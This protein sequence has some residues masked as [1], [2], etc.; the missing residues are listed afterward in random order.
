MKHFYY[1]WSTLVFVFLHAMLLAQPADLH[2]GCHFTKSQIPMRTLTPAEQEALTTSNERSDTL[3]ILNYDITLEITDFGGK[4]IHGSCAIAFT[5]VTEG[6]ETM[7]L[8]LLAL[9]IDSI[10]MD[11]APLP[12]S[13]DGNQITITFPESP[14]LSD[15]LE[16]EVFYGGQTTVAESNFGG[17]NFEQGIAYNLGIGLGE[18][19]YNFGRGWFPCFDNFVEWATYDLN[20]IST[21]T[22]RAYC[23]GTFLSEE[24]WEGNKRMRRYR[25]AQPLPTY[26]VGIA[27]SDFVTVDYVHSGQYGDHPVQLVARPT[28]IDDVVTSFEF[29]PDAIDIF[30]SWYGPYIWE[31]VGF[32]LTPRGAME[33]STN[34]AYPFGTGASGATPAQNRLMAHELAHH[35]WGNITTLS[36]PENMWIKEGNAEYGAHLFTEFVNGKDAFRRQVKSNLL[37]VLNSAHVDDD[38]YHP[39]SGIPYEHTYG[40]HTYQKGASMLHNMR[41]YLGDSLFT[42]GQK[43][44]L[45]H[46]TY[47][48]INAEQYRDHLTL[49][50]GVDMTDYFDAWIFN[51]GFANYELEAMDVTANGN[52]YDVNLI[53]QQKLHN[54][55]ELHQNAPVQVTFFGE[56]WSE[57]TRQF[58]A[59]G[60]FSSA[61]TTLPFE[62][63]FAIINHYQLVNL[64]RMNQSQVIYEV[65]S[66][67]TSSINFLALAATE[68]PDSAFLSIVHHRTAA[69]QPPNE[70]NI[71]MSSN[72]YWSIRGLFPEGFE[73]LGNIQ[74]KGG[75]GQLDEDLASVTDEDLIMA[76]RPTVESDW[77]EYPHYNKIA[78]GTSGF[79]Q[80]TTILPGDYAFANGAFLPVNTQD[81]AVSEPEIS[82]SPN[83]TY[84]M[85]QV[86]VRLEGERQPIRINIYNVAGQL[87]ETIVFQDSKTVQTEIDVRNW[88]NGIYVLEVQAGQ[89]RKSVE[90]VVQH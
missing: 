6:A 89:Q 72:H 75:A 39:L 16:L 11:N 50:T 24:P 8:D 35:W 1:F 30:E 83:P 54:A 2:H 77:Q 49:A 51:P 26:L 73:L 46:Y 53:I 4:T 38:G 78:Q 71:Q 86:Q 59:S 36:G 56:D 44:V 70:P 9:N 5:P 13:Y 28:I 67:N 64:A 18:N 55:P 37:R 21:N 32:V 87:M 7:V 57:E 82:I 22:Q 58:T 47:Q 79:I 20:I 14:A 25:M 88:A 62:P 69:D 80:L 61:S 45:E 41:A 23:V 74:Y 66:L 17:L 31:R 10:I 52:L 68:V 90:W 15:T 3:D 48:S 60:E 81:I 65:G 12:Y 76:W 27:V 19:P 33:H 85:A 43:A 42:I 34:I 84:S 63:A 29:L 40:T